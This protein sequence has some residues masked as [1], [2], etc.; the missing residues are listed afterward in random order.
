M[1]STCHASQIIPV[2]H[3]HALFLSL[4][5]AAD[6][7]IPLRSAWDDSANRVAGRVREGG[8]DVR[9][10]KGAS[11]ITHERFDSVVM[12]RV[13][14]SARLVGAGVFGVVRP[15]CL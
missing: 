1:F 3:S 4:C 8:G 15:V 14:A 2:R 9:G 6:S 12:L 10:R 11:V 5:S 7:S 13:C